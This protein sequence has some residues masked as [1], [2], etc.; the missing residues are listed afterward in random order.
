M[1][2]KERCNVVQ[3][4]IDKSVSDTDMN[5]E[6]RILTEIQQE[7]GSKAEQLK[8]KLIETEIK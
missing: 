3:K 1:K 4:F 2:M 6:V 8:K 5:Y 7:I